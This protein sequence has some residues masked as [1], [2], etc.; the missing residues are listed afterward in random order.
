MSPGAVQGSKALFNRILDDG[1]AEQ[2]AAERATIGAQIGSAEPDRSGHGRL[3]EAPTRLRRRLTNAPIMTDEPPTRRTVR[4]PLSGT[5]DARSSELG[6]SG[7]PEGAEAFDEAVGV[8]EVGV[9]AVVGP[10]LDGAVRRSVRAASR[11]SR[12]RDRVRTARGRHVVARVA[13]ERGVDRGGDLVFRLASAAAPTRRGR[14]RGRHGADRST[15]ATSS[16]GSRSPIIISN[17]ASTT[18][19]YC[20]GSRSIAS[21]GISW[22]L[23]ESSCNDWSTF[24]MLANGSIEPAAVTTMPPSE[25]PTTCGRDASAAAMTVATSPA[26]E[27]R[28]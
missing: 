2:F 6:R 18:R 27:T 14:P 3:R 20:S 16:P 1:A 28:S 10:V 5:A 21:A 15:R 12:R 4:G 25:C 11:R 23:N 19:W 24:T 22:A 9:V 8:D 17:I 26:I 7:R 13:G